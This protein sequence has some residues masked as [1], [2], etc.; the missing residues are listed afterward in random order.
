MRVALLVSSGVCNA[1][2]S[3][4]PDCSVVVWQCKR[5]KRCG[6]DPW[7]RKMPWN[8]KWQ[9][10]SVFLPGKSHG[11]KSLAGY[12]PWGHKES[13]MTE[14]THRVCVFMC[15]F[16]LSQFIM[17][18]EVSLIS[19]NLLFSLSGQKIV[20]VGNSLP[21]P[22]LKASSPY[23]YPSTWHAYLK[24]KTSY[25]GNIEYFSL[26]LMTEENESEVIQSCLTLCDPMN[27]SL[28]VSSVHRIFQARVLEWVAISFSRRGV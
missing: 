17:N 19:R 21:H 3:G 20:Y 23:L 15:V 25:T 2:I 13:D 18:K 4:F 5:H 1:Y 27:G 7:V 6:F 22:P 16:V 11:Q 14:N 12:S 8:R 24:A 10:T 28:P 26:L 9:L